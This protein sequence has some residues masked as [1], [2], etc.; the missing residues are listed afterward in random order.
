MKFFTLIIISFLFSTT[1][2]NANINDSLTPNITYFVASNNVRVRAFP[3]QS[4]RIL[5][6]LALNDQVQI[7]SP[8]T[9]YNDKFIQ[10]NIVSTHEKIDFAEKYFIGKDFL[11]ETEMDY[12]EFKGQY[13]IVV[14]VASETLRLYQRVC[15]D[16]SCPNKMIMQTEVVV[17]ED[18]DHAKDEKG[19][20]RSLLGSYRVT[21]WAKFYQDPEG[22][23]PAW[24]RDGYPPVPQP[25]A[26]W[27]E[28]FA[29]KNMPLGT[30][31][32]HEGKMRGAF[33]WYTA[34]VTP[35]PFGQWTHG[36]L[37][38]GS[39]KDK[40]IKRV[41]KLLINVVSDPRSS[42]CTRNNNEAIAFIRNMIDVGTPIIKIYAREQILDPGLKNYPPEL[43]F[44]NYAL[45]K[46]KSHAIDRDEVL[47]HLKIPLRDLNAWWEAKRNGSGLILSP[48]DPLNQILE[49][50]TY[51]LDTMPEA[52]EYTRGKINIGRKIGR[53]GNVY[54]IKP[55]DMHGNFY[56]D[57]GILSDYAHPTKKLEVGGFPDEITPPWMRIENIKF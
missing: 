35:K 38:W 19:K 14:N 53:K 4:G 40:F 33:G 52:I 29:K 32:K 1:F 2:V 22:H 36:T 24:Y 18:I 26:I 31:G 45:T 42:G 46:N 7:I 6:E 21:G 57:A 28:W 10:I 25:D 8:A 16:N 3:D 41:K 49:I 17:G 27:S 50:G 12:K 34:F 20:G 13:F 55:E 48:E 23:Y 30:D 56:V 47:S 37:G 51:Q 15:P 43:K 9:I 5:G 39:D 11:A 54:G 44:W